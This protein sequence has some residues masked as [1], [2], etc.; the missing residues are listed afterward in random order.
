MK[1]Y[2]LSEQDAATV[3]AILLTHATMQDHRALESMSLLGRLKRDEP[4]DELIPDLQGQIN[5]FEA[6]TDNLTRIA[7]I[8]N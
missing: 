4:D 2:Q 7:N 3:K 8:F 6:D 5:D 1:Q